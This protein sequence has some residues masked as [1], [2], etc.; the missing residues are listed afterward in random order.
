MK[1]IMYVA[2][3]SRLP[4]KNHEF[5]VFVEK[6]MQK[7]PESCQKI[8]FLEKEDETMALVGE[9]M[10]GAGATE[11][12]VVPM[13]LFPAMH[14]TK[15]IPEHVAN[16]R[17]KHPDVA[18]RIADTFGA[19]PETIAVAASRIRAADPG[20]D[21]KILVIAHG[22]AS[23]AE[24]RK[25]M[26]SVVA[27]LGNNVSLGMLHGEPNYKQVATE[28]AA[29]NQNIYWMPYFLFKGQL[30]DKI[31]AGITEVSEAWRETDCLNLDLELIN[32][33]LRKIEEMSP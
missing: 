28:L 29:I 5:R 1:A 20:P 23:Y 4:E 16:L 32:A 21:A 13:L 19:E 17:A 22:S 8:A 14:A 3:G 9:A 18:F 10:I 15:D 27:Q 25:Q 30:V 6:I 2:H 24:P 31:R 11:I 33:V 7:R 12:T 26:E